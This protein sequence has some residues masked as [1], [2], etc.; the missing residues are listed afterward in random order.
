MDV[1]IEEKVCSISKIRHRPPLLTYYGSLQAYI[2][3]NVED[4]LLNWRFDNDLI[5]YYINAGF[6][7][8]QEAMELWIE[9]QRAFYGKSK[10]VQAMKIGGLL[11]FKYQTNV[12]EL[13]ARMHEKRN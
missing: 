12:L 4:I 6:T 9:I 7:D 5:R 3:E 8:L 1:F 10:V 2:E 11:V 13:V